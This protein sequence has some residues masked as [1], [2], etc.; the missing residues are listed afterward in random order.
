M[1]N[2]ELSNK[3][4]KK[5]WRINKKSQGD[6]KAQMIVL[7]GVILAIS[8]FIIASIPSQIVNMEGAISR[9]QATSLLSEFVHIKEVFGKSLNYNLADI[10]VDNDP[11]TFY[12]EIDDITESFEKTKDS[13]YLLELNQDILFD[14]YHDTNW[15]WFSHT[16][17]DGLV[18]KVQ[19]TITL[20]DGETQ[21]SEHVEYLIICNEEI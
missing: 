6:Q 13:L 5:T 4:S 1:E 2:Y 11:I 8:V 7:M 19:V 16:S 21:I 10:N 18:Y 17:L 20:D 15:Y 9:E 12:G 14:A 3:S